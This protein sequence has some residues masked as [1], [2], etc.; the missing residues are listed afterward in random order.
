MLRATALRTEGRRWA[1]RRA[2]TSCCAAVA[3]LAIE[4]AVSS[5]GATMAALF[6]AALLVG[7]GAAADDTDAASTSRRHVGRWTSIP[8]WTPSC[9]NG[10]FPDSGDDPTRVFCCEWV[11]TSAP[12][13]PCVSF[14]AA[15]S[16]SRWRSV[17]LYAC[18]PRDAPTCPAEFVTEVPQPPPVSCILRTV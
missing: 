11:A 8:L 1:S 13:S 2:N 4:A 17:L 9:W 18:S 12:P 16:L 5:M 6:A 10:Y 14:S 3:T 15:L 7:T